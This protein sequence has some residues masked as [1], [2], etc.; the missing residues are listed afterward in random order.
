MSESLCCLIELRFP[1]SDSNKKKCS[2][3]TGAWFGK[4]RRNS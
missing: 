1:V 3:L 4:V 2:T